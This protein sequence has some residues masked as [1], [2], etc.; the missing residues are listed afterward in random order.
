MIVDGL[1]ALVPE[2]GSGG[3][4][5]AGVVYSP[6]SEATEEIK[7]LSNT[8][9]A[10]Y[11]KSGVAVITTTL[12]SG[13]NKFH[14]SLFEFFRNDKLD[15]NQWFS[16]A[17]KTG[18]S[19]LRQNIFGGSVSGPIWKNHTFFFFDYQGF[20]QISAGQPTR[21][22]MPTAAMGQ[23]D[24]SN[25]LNAQGQQIVI[26]DPLT[27]GPGEPRTPFAG[28]VIPQACMDPAALKIWSF[29]PTQRRS[30]G[31][32]FTAL[33]NNTYLI[34]APYNEAQGDIKVDHNLTANQR[35]MF[36]YSRWDITRDLTPTLPGSSFDNPNPA[37]TGLW[38]GP[39]KS[40]QFMLADTWTVS[41]HAI[42]DFRVGYTR[43]ESIQAW[44]TGCQPLFNSCQT[45]FNPSKAG[46]PSYLGAYS[47]TQGFPSITFSWGYQALGVGNQQYWGP[48]TIAL[49]PSWTQ[50]VGRHVLKFGFDGRRQHY[51][52]GGGSDRAGQFNFT[53]TATRR[54]SNV[55]NTQHEGNAFASFLL[56]TPDTGSISSVSI[57]NVKSDYFAWY[58]QD[59][60][61]VSKRL[62]LNLGLRYDVSRPMWDKFGQM[63]F[64][65]T[66]V[67][68]P[69]N[70]DINRA[71]IPAGMR[72]EIRGGL[73]FA[74][75]GPLK[76]GQQYHDHRLE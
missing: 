73:E 63:S 41:P 27:A 21:S 20:R 1:S 57:S 70:A 47:D 6:N 7:I 72:S 68:N 35:L 62:T 58:L 67:V 12:K 75:Q 9:S 69:V 17:T 5:T 11:G 56:G 39:R 43:Y 26:Y 18:K 38:R 65:N 28:N 34:P 23:G 15:A 54:V 71:L 32:P 51:I 3:S 31:D 60:F 46:M 36:R 59:D 74:N 42:F 66:D 55:S 2:G 52:R 24:F 14:G 22:T 45:P 16:N 48:D 61:K 76:G 50:I 19:E 64:L 4:G 44:L 49:Q 30:A 37:D 40:Y 25:L 33:G 13:T 53:D 8:Y 29:V 10:E